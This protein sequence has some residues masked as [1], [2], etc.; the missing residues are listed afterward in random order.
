MFEFLKFRRTSGG[1][2]HAEK[3]SVVVVAY[4]MPRELPRTIK[5]LSSDMQIGLDE[6]DYEI[7]IVDN[8]SRFPFDRMQISGLGKNIRFV[9][10]TNPDASPA[11]AINLGVSQARHPLVGIL[12][13]GARM[14]SPGLL[15]RAREALS[16]GPRTVVGTIG[17]HLGNKVQMESVHEGYDQLAEDNLLA[18][19][20][21]EENGYRLFDISVLAGSSAKGWFELPEETNA[22]FLH[23]SQFERLGGFDERFRS[24][25]GGL[26]NHH[27]WAQCCNDPGGRVVMLL[28]EATFHQFHGG[29]ATNARQSPWAAFAQEYQAIAGKP[30]APVSGNPLLFGSLPARLRTQR[31][32]S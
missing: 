26:V 27:F 18:S 3:L 11:K 21:W 6:D 7:V 30:Y 23:R 10:V 19:V 28:G 24:P 5:T 32:S 4:N 22:L 20:R 12:I 8:G 13:D 25:G 31:T 17:F 16:L 15:A 14:A 1:A 29:V 9:D 2:Q